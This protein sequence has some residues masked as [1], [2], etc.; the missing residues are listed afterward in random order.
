MRL[1][2]AE[3]D[4]GAARREAVLEVQAKSLREVEAARIKAARAF[5]RAETLQDRCGEQVCEGVIAL[6]EE[7]LNHVTA[8]PQTYGW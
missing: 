2:L 8:G 7:S 3:E 1:R 4:V 5:A 6:S